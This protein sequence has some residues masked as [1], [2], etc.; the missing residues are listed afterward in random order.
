MKED[1]ELEWKG[2]E[3]KSKGKKG[4]EGW[5]GGK[6]GKGACEIVLAVRIACQ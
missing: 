3:C 6:G 1:R 5:E 4:T 2:W